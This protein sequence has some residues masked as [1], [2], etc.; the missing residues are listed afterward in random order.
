MAQP[1]LPNKANAQHDYQS[2]ADRVDFD[3]LTNAGDTYPT[4]VV[5]GCAITGDPSLNVNVA[6]GNYRINGRPV[7]TSGVTDLA[8]DAAHATLYRIDLIYGNTSG[9][10][11]E[12]AGTPATEGTA[13]APTVPA[14]CVAIA[15]V[16]VDPTV[17]SIADADCVDKRKW[18]PSHDGIH[19]VKWYGAVGDGSTDDSAAFQAA[20]DAA[21]AQAGTVYIPSTSNPGTDYY[22]IQGGVDIDNFFRGLKVIGNGWGSQLV[23]DGTDS[24]I[25]IG[26]TGDVSGLVIADLRIDCYA[27][28]FAAIEIDG[29][30]FSQS[31]VRDCY[32]FAAV[33]GSY[34][35]HGTGNWG[36]YDVLWLRNVYSGD[37]VA[38]STPLV[39]L[40]DTQSGWFNNNQFVGGRTIGSAT[41]TAGAHFYIESQG[42]GS[43]D[44]KNVI[45]K[46]NFEIPNYGAVHIEGAHS[47][48]LR[49]LG[50]YDLTTFGANMIH[51]DKYSTGNASIKDVI[52]NC[53]TI[54]GISR[55]SFYD[56]F[57]DGTGSGELLII[58]SGGHLATSGK[59]DLNGKSATLINPSADTIDGVSADTK[60]IR[61]DN[62]GVFNVKDYGA[63]GDG[64]TDDTTEIQAAIDAANTAGGG[65]VFF[66]PGTYRTTSTLDYYSDITLKGTNARE[67][68][69]NTA[70]SVTVLEPSSV[71]A[72][73]YSVWLEDISFWRSSG[74]PAVCIDWDRITYGGMR[75]VINDTSQPL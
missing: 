30:E 4:G 21:I 42:A 51:L 2:Y 28:G 74:T 26:N 9:T 32:L 36:M 27:S 66:P 22:S 65:V 12:T 3:I 39:N 43:Y 57:I 16:N 24:V 64:S 10:I 34:C 73:M 19:N 54:S 47:W 23:G 20:I 41:A 58:N 25:R 52:E 31:T 40:V 53:H 1:F 70:H 45:E 75:N 5:D 29:N 8:L 61:A 44:Y 49:D 6:S 60:I 69:I 59:I 55:G 68:E 18:V 67:V 14:D 71:A 72:R 11:L 56:I 37:G 17:T 35:V 46:I 48:A 50:I 15:F 63:V 13:E 7:A 62:D 38:I 33:A